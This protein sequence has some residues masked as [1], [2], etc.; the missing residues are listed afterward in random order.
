MKKITKVCALFAA[1]TAFMLAACDAGG[2][3]RNGAGNCS[4]DND[5]QLFSKG[6]CYID[7]SCESEDSKKELEKH[8]LLPGSCEYTG[9]QAC[10]RMYYLPKD[11][12]SG[13]GWE[14]SKPDTEPGFVFCFTDETYYV[15][16][17]HGDISC[18]EYKPTSSDKLICFTKDSNNSEQYCYYAPKDYKPETPKGYTLVNNSDAASE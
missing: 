3:C 18:S 10:Q 9:Y 15:P 11:A 6:T 17:I 16:T 4:K 2:Y 1:G 14:C 8:G 7:I 12:P 13:K 5:C